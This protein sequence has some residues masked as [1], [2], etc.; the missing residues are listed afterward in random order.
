MRSIVSALIVCAAACSPAPRDENASGQMAQN[1]AKSAPVQSLG[2]IEGF[3]FIDRFENHTPNEGERKAWRNA[4]VQIGTGQ[5]TYQLE[6]NQSGNPAQIRNGVLVDTGDGNRIQTLIGCG[7]I[8]EDRDE[9]FFRYFGNRPRV[10]RTGEGS[11]TLATADTALVLLDADRYLQRYGASLPDI[12]GRWV[13]QYAENYDG[14]ESSGASI[15]E[16]P[17]V[18]TISAR[19]LVWSICPN[20]AVIGEFTAEHRFERRGKVSECV[21]SNTTLAE[22]KTMMKVM[23]GNPAFVRLSQDRI[24][25]FT[26]NQAVALQSEQTVLNPPPLP[27][28]SGPPSTSPPPPPPTDYTYKQP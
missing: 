6:C 15:G 9:R 20:A 18:L 23:V 16:Q 21:G 11:I 10:T 24:V 28:S 17:G 4:F 26:G 22:G 27:V 3:W 19:R 12:A 14:W 13:P 2:A 1:A 7:K 25:M 8:A 5:L